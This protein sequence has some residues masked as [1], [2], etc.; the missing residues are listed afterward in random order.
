[1]GMFMLSKLGKKDQ[2]GTIR[3]IANV[4]QEEKKVEVK[5]K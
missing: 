3:L 2:V 4:Y 5:V 1:M